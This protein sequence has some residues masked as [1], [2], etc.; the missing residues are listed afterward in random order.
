MGQNPSVV[1]E[2]LLEG[3]L[4][5]KRNIEERN[6]ILKASRMSSDPS[7][8]P[9]GS[10]GG[11]SSAYDSA[12]GAATAPGAAAAAASGGG[13]ESGVVP[14]VGGDRRRTRSV[15]VRTAHGEEKLVEPDTASDAQVER[16]RQEFSAAVAAETVNY[17]QPPPSFSAALTRLAQAPA[18][19][20]TRLRGPSFRAE[21]L[22][23]MA[24]ESAGLPEDPP[25]VSPASALRGR[26]RAPTMLHDLRA[27][28]LVP[29]K[30]VA[31]QNRLTV[32]L[33]LDETLMFARNGPLYA[34][35]YLQE[36][37]AFI[38]AACEVIVWTAG[39]RAYA[40]AV[41]REI[42]PA[43]VISHCIYRH[44]KWFSGDDYTK[45]LR[46]L[47]RPLETTLILENTPSCVEKNIFNGI[48]VQDYDGAAGSDVTLLC[49][50]QF[51]QQLLRSRLPVP[52]FI[53]QCPMLTLL[54]YEGS[55]FY[56]LATDAVDS[57]VVRQNL[58]KG[59]AAGQG[60]GALQS[61]AFTLK[62]TEDDDEDDDEED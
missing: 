61:R 57:K 19:P 39:V 29:P 54:Q 23:T 12:P 53:A 46:A 3:T 49:V 21:Y 2:T 43:G 4:P 20:A 62:T 47:G 25:A 18:Q 1:V 59:G 13:S 60:Q 40:Q 32:V 28:G 11:S 45:E 42:D 16:T 41:V 14:T 30:E 17:V 33:D 9:G 55:L 24:R 37:L 56:F 27:T 52:K 31:Q 15:R 44:Q 58:D 51:I 5:T 8:S 22:A 50:A 35:P 6:A 34:R 48:I 36:F 26:Q 7:A 10:A 38:G